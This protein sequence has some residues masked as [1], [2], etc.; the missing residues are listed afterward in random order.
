EPVP[1]FRKHQAE[2]QKHGW[3][4]ESRH[5]VSEIDHLVEIVELAR[6]VKA[7]RNETRQAQNVEVLRL[8]GAA[9]PEVDEETDDQVCRSHGI[10]IDHGP[11]QRLFR[12]HQH[13]GE[14]HAAALQAVFRPAPWSDCY[15]D[16]LDV[17]CPLNLNPIDIQ[18]PVCGMNSRISPR[19][20][21]L[22]VQRLHRSLAVY[23]NHAVL[24][25]AEAVLLL[26]VDK[27]RHT[28]G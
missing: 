2:V 14:F 9:A 18:Q 16:F 24:G 26:K 7:K 3:R 13:G 23:P 21:R 10:L 25:A 4:Y 6:V 5:Q 27:C 12:H 15:Q 20:G 22:Y 19:A 28:G 17:R 1:W 8:L 11:F